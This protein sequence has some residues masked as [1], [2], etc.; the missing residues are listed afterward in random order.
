M[1]LGLLLLGACASPESSNAPTGQQGAPPAAPPPN[2]V[3]DEARLRAAIPRTA[4]SV[5]EAI[6]YAE[7]AGFSCYWGGHPYIDILPGFIAYCSMSCAGSVESGWWIVVMA[8]PDKEL[9]VGSGRADLFAPKTEE[10]CKYPARAYA[11]RTYDDGL[12]YE[13]SML[14][15]RPEGKGAGRWK[16]GT[17]YEGEWSRGQPHGEGA[18]EHANG[19]L[20]R[21]Q[22]LAGRPHGEGAQLSRDG[23]RYEGEFVDGK[24][25]GKGTETKSDGTEYR[26]EFSD[27]KPNGEGTETKSDGNEY[28]GRFVDGKRSGRGSATYPDGSS[29]VGEWRD[30]LWHGKGRLIVRIE[31]KWYRGTERFSGSWVSGRL[32]GKGEIKMRDGSVALVEFVDGKCVLGTPPTKAGCPRGVSVPS[33]G[34][35]RG[36]KR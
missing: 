21:G 5:A 25:H 8:K 22:W 9:A 12:T 36:S 4:S 28:Q 24:Q 19:D 34:S 2:V 7:R 23:T 26:G 3:E 17:R 18:M 27:G 20:Y 33:E 32:T 10:A 6:D 1:A 14:R 29:Y 13:G 30:D 15:G 35:L 11:R 16:D 31:R